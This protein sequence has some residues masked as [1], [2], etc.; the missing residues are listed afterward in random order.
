MDFHKLIAQNIFWRG[1]YFFSQFLLSVLISRLFKANGS[2]TI[3]YVINNLSLLLLVLSLSL[4]SGTTYYVAKNEIGAKKISIFLLS[5]SLGMTLIFVIGFKCLEGNF[6]QLFVNAQEYVVACSAFVLG[7]LLTTYFSALFFARKNFFL[8]NFI[9]CCINLT[10]IILLLSDGKN[11]F[12]HAHFVTIYFCSFLLQ[13]FVV[14]LFYFFVQPKTQERFFL[15]TYEL[16]KL[17]R[18]SL[19]AL[20]ANFI[21]FLVYR[22]DYWFVKY[23]CTA[24]DLG[25]YIQVSKLGQT[26]FVLPSIIAA[27]IFPLTAAEKTSEVKDNIRSIVSFLLILYGSVCFLLICTGKWLF[28]VVYGNSFD[29]MYLPFV[30]S[31]PGVLS[32][33]ILYPFTAYYAGKKRISVNLK[34]ALIA[35]ILIILGDLLCI[36]YYGI[37]GAALVSSAG[38]LAY[39]FYVMNVFAKEYQISLWNFFS[40]SKKEISRI[41]LIIDNDTKAQS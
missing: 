12:I 3:Y 27:A 39:Q 15:A 20:A 14:M 10:M 40:I 17:F 23:F 22:I 34:G 31:V 29:S 38:Y 37:R 28:P 32:L 4:E 9:L 5:W 33:S 7:V 16:D 36:P 18:Y 13:G 30:F 1:L 24:A 41:F 19:F 25:N 2:G 6:T 11:P 26:F 21:F 35:L 8:P